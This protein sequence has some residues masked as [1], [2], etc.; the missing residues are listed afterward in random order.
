M[1]DIEGDFVVEDVGLLV[2]CEVGC[3]ECV[4]TLI[5]MEGGENKLHQFPVSTDGIIAASVTSS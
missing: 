2:G 1:D 5:E 4:L 3:A